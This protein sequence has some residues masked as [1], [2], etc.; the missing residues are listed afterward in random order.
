MGWVRNLREKRENYQEHELDKGLQVVTVGTLFPFLA[1]IRFPILTAYGP[2]EPRFDAS[3]LAMVDGYP[4]WTSKLYAIDYDPLMLVVL[5]VVLFGVAGAFRLWQKAWCYWLLWA[6]AVI[7]ALA[8]VGHLA[9]IFSG[10]VPALEDASRY[11]ES[12][13]S[14]S[15]NYVSAWAVALGSLAVLCGCWLLRNGRKAMAK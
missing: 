2:P 11:F 13:H 8:Y 7:Y 3:A 9:F 6:L 15:Y 4:S 1:L 5:P 14:A 10:V 12:A